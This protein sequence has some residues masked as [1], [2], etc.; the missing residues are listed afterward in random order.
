MRGG[1]LAVVVVVSLNPDAPECEGTNEYACEN[2]GVPCLM[3]EKSSDS[4]SAGDAC[5][6]G[7]P[8]GTETAKD[9]IMCEIPN[10]EELE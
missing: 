5:G 7:H 10:E 8:H 1:Y 3:P 2:E 4:L 9:K 6:V